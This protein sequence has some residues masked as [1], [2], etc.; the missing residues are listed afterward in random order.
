MSTHV[1][2]TGRTHPADA[3][4]TQSILEML[5]LV[6]GVPESRQVEGRWQ[7]LLG[8]IG[9]S[10]PQYFRIAY[11]QPLIHELATEAKQLFEVSGLHSYNSGSNSIA[12][13]LT[14]AWKHFQ[15]DPPGFSCWEGEQ[16]Q[17]LKKDF[18]LI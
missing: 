5:R 11:P 16:V 3:A 17:R 7:E 18:N 2:G 8:M 4:R 14:E 10:E 15:A 1:F 9:T 12:D 13:L 6:A